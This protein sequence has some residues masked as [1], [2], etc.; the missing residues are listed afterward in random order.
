MTSMTPYITPKSTQDCKHPSTSQVVNT[1]SPVTQLAEAFAQLHRPNKS[2]I[3]HP[4]LVV[5]ITSTYGFLFPLQ[6]VTQLPAGKS[7]QDHKH[8]REHLCSL[9]PSLATLHNPPPAKKKKSSDAHP[10][11]SRS[12]GFLFYSFW[13]LTVN[14]ICR[15]RTRR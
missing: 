9:T 13:S 12:L 10:L 5:E 7:T 6:S 1:Y 14:L 8:A 15:R 11:L 4:L 2:F 3:A